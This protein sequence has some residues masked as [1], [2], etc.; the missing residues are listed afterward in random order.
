M[1]VDLNFSE[2]CSAIIG[3]LLGVSFCF[4]IIRQKEPMVQGR[5][6]LLMC[7]TMCFCF[8]IGA[9]RNIIAN[10]NFKTKEG[11]FRFAQ[12]NQKIESLIEQ[13]AS[14]RND[15][16]LANTVFKNKDVIQFDD[17]SF[18][19]KSHLIPDNIRLS[20]EKIEEIL[21]QYSRD[22]AGE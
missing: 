19:I 16:Q 9:G 21:Q 7:F 3:L 1:F 8:G 10:Y 22:V 18:L 5:Y 2:V 11:S 13:T 12:L 14:I 6:L 15:V 17:N 20:P 4:I